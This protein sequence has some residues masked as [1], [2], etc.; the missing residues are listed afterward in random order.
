MF[1]Q[2]V[3]VKANVYRIVPSAQT[4]PGQPDDNDQH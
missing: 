2:Q 3:P 1:N 4:D